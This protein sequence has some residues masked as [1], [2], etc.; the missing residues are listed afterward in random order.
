MKNKKHLAISGIILI[1]FAWSVALFAQVNEIPDSTTPSWKIQ[2]IQDTLADKSK[3]PIMVR[4]PA[5]TFTMGDIQGIGQS[6][7][8]P[9]HKVVIPNSFSIGKYPVT[10][11]E[12]DKFTLVTGKQ[13]VSDFKWGRGSRPVFNVNLNDAEAYAE[14]LSEQT[15]HKYR[16]PSEAEWEYAA[17]A[18]SRTIYPWG[19]TIGKSN[20]NCS[21]CGSQWDRK[22][23]APVGQFPPNRWGLYDMQG[24]L[25]ELTA[26][27]WNYSYENAPADGSAWREGDCVR[28]V[29][30]GGSWGDPPADLRA[31]TRLRSYSGTRTIVIGFRLVR[32]D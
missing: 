23:T 7:E 29:L 8:K 13:P 26:D 2:E 4:I 22:M 19:D 6:Y 1:A 3:G 28:S 21:K 12:Y 20:A 15:G 16:L 24:N 27:C 32:E 31:S 10:F 11:D 25:W 9:V 30:R 17:R 5:G 14:W 18:G